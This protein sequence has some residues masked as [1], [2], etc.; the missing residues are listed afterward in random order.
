MATKTAIIISNKITLVSDY[1][2]IKCSFTVPAKNIQKMIEVTSCT[3]VSKKEIKLPHNHYAGTTYVVT[4]F[5]SFGKI[6]SFLKSDSIIG[7]ENTSSYLELLNDKFHSYNDTHLLCEKVPLYAFGQLYITKF[8]SSNTHY[9]AKDGRKIS[10]S[11]SA[12][13]NWGEKRYINFKGTWYSNKK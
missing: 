7:C 9:F 3:V 2:Q 8:T 11:H 10:I 4:I 6:K 1:S 5:V 13:N 12:W